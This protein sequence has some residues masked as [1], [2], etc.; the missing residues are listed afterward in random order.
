MCNPGSVPAHFNKFRECWFWKVIWIEVKGLMSLSPSECRWINIAV[1]ANGCCLGLL[2]EIT[3][4]WIIIVTR[5]TCF[6]L[7]SQCFLLIVK[8]LPLSL[9]CQNP[10]QCP[11]LTS[12]LKAYEKGHKHDFYLWNYFLLERKQKNLHIKSLY[13]PCPTGPGNVTLHSSNRCPCVG[14]FFCKSLFS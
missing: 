9:L 3:Y 5:Y 2:L 14:K 13:V 6:I 12:G 7:F 8:L 11:T 1:S 4:L 10:V